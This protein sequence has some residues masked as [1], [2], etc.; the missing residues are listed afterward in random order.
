MG[1][2][3][4][5]KAKRGLMALR[6]I[7]VSVLISIS[8]FLIWLI[9]YNYDYYSQNDPTRI[10][11]KYVFVLPTVDILYIVL[12]SLLGRKFFV[13]YIFTSDKLQ[14]AIENSRWSKPSS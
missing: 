10:L 14:D 6:L 4:E 5:K 13:F 9:M 2:W 11:D 8:G 7:L 1:D 12:V 3:N